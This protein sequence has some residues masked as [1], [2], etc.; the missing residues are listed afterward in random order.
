MKPTAYVD[1][2]DISQFHLNK[3]WGSIDINCYMKI[4]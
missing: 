4:I 2:E 1:A 3:P